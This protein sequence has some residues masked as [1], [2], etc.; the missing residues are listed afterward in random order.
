MPWTRM[1]SD[2]FGLHVNSHMCR[3]KFVK[4]DGHRCRKPAA[5]FIFLL[6]TSIWK[7]NDETHDKRANIK[8][9]EKRLYSC[10]A[11]VS[12]RELQQNNTQ[13]SGQINWTD[14]WFNWQLKMTFCA[15]LSIEFADPHILRK[16]ATEQANG[17]TSL[18]CVPVWNVII[19]QITCWLSQHVNFSGS[20]SKCGQYCPIRPCPSASN[21]LAVPL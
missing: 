6:S 15:Q 1:N 2:C 17:T 11:I 21:G 19:N 10:F 8:P 13:Q 20:L 18:S 4:H 12:F 3:T 16:V 14:I 7:S 9:T 5:S